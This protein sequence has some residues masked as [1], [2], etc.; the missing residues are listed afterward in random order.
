M[1]ATSDGTTNDQSST[2]SGKQGFTS[3]FVSKEDSKSAKSESRNGLEKHG[4]RELK[5]FFAP[6]GSLFD[7]EKSSVGASQLEPPSMEKAR[8]KRKKDEADL[9]NH[10]GEADPTA[11]SPLSKASKKSKVKKEDGEA[12]STKKKH[13]KEGKHS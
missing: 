6:S 1:T 13:K 12:S 8:K 11:S 7:E 10:D 2:S 9:A 4:L 5:G 3:L